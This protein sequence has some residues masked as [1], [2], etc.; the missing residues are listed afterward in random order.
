VI[1]LYCPRRACSPWREVCWCMCLHAGFCGSGA[2]RNRLRC[3]RV[4]VP[5]LDRPL[6]VL[7]GLRPF[8]EDGNRGEFTVERGQFTTAKAAIGSLPE[9]SLD[10]RHR[11]CQR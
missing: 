4:F 11:D 3:R 7:K 8:A 10:R 6:A 2:P 9:L 1:Q 5:L